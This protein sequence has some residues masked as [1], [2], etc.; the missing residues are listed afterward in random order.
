MKRRPV[1]SSDT[2]GLPIR[3][4]DAGRGGR[5]RRIFLAAG[6]LIL[7]NG[8]A[9]PKPEW[10][11]SRADGPVWPAP[12]E[13]PRIQYLNE[14]R[15]TEG[16]GNR[17]GAPAGWRRLLFGPD[18]PISLV[19]PHAVAVHPTR[20]LVAVADTNGGAVL[21]FD[22]DRH[23]VERVPCR[24]AD[25]APIGCPVG[26][27][28]KGEALYIADSKPPRVIVKE[29]AGQRRVLGEGQL[30]RPAG[31]AACTEQDRIYVADAGSH[32]VFAFDSAGTLLFRTGARGVGTG[33]FNFPS[34]I[35]CAPDGSLVVADSL[36]FRVQQLRADGSPIAAFG[37]KGDAA[38]DFA[39]PKGVAVDPDG[40]IW[41]VDAHFENIQ[42]FTPGGQLLLAFGGEGAGPGQFW[43]PAGIH[44]DPRR[45]LWIAD[46]YNRRVQ[47]F[48]ILQ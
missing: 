30:I 25:D 11:L 8:C 13:Q 15:G 12:P 33:E 37:Q 45:R 10:T 32:S 27:A 24:A 22:L 38:G 40:N 6:G 26:V 47:V 9:S 5:A 39:L 46:T 44:I 36:N 1:H 19:T 31:L 20:S 21:V 48:Q 3:P 14:L 7:A 23:K 42:A 17:A 43:L 34:Q 4:K 28:W 18:P 35:A 29:A 41:V 16:F 2:T